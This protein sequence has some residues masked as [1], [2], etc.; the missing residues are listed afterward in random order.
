MNVSSMDDGPGDSVIP[1]GLGD[2]IMEKIEVSWL[3]V[4][5]WLK[6]WTLKVKNSLEY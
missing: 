6:D 3:S 2:N 1:A 5:T 4:E